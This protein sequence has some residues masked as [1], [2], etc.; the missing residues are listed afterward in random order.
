[1]P[2]DNIGKRITDL[3]FLRNGVQ[4]LFDDHSSFI[5]DTSTLIEFYLY[6]DKLIDDKTYKAVKKAGE[7]LPYKKYLE[8]LLAKGRYSESQIR[9]KLKAKKALDSVINELVFY[10]KSN[11]LIDDLSLKNDLVDYYLQKHVGI[12]YIQS[13]LR[14]KGFASSII[15]TIEISDKVQE[16]SASIQLEKLSKKL[17]K[18]P[19]LA[20]KEM[21]YRILKDKGFEDSIIHHV[22]S[23]LSSNDDDVV[24]L[25]L[26]KDY[27]TAMRKYQKKYKDWDLN[28]RI[29]IYLKTKGYNNQDI[30]KKMG[31]I[32]NDLD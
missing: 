23:N 2:S 1:V 8:Q 17:Q 18:K 24:E 7:F 21:V 15:E 5:I 29:F 28:H 22:L 19:Y 11:G 9:L 14:T 12:K 6:K 20:R 13:I 27:S 25:Q 31:A 3:K 4:I 32:T 30:K 10:A 26:E 16:K